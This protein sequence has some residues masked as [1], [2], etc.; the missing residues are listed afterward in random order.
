MITNSINIQYGGPAQ[1]FSLYSKPYMKRIN[2][3]RMSNG[4]QPPKFQQFDGKGNPKQEVAHFIKTCENDLGGFFVDSRDVSLST[5]LRSLALSSSRNFIVASSNSSSKAS[6]FIVAGATFASSPKCRLVNSTPLRYVAGKDLH[7]LTC[8]AAKKIIIYIVIFNV[9]Q[10]RRSSSSSSLMYCSQEDLHLHLLSCVA[11]ERVFIFIFNLL[12]QP[13]GSSSS[14]PL[15]WC[16]K[17]DLHLHLQCD[18]AETIILSSSSMRCTR[19]DHHL[20]LQCDA[21]E[22][23]IIFIFHM[24]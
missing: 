19:D 2:N 7:L 13:R 11:V 24:V 10:P 6:N 17:D 21:T 20:Y 5:F 16:S 12:L 9:L 14:S 4:Y 18:T 22:T 23:I 1:T 15:M 8:V 3:L